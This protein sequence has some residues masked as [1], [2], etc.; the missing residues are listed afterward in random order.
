MWSQRIENGHP[1]NITWLGLLNFAMFQPTFGYH[2][3]ST[4]VVNLIYG[5]MLCKECPR[6]GG[7][8]IGSITILVHSVGVIRVD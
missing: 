1:Y 6:C 4:S 7:L 3:A 8:K 5:Y 2:L